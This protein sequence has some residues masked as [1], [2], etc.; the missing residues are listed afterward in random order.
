MTTTTK[1]AAEAVLR[2]LPSV[3]GAFVKEDVHGQPREVHLLVRPGPDAGG[4]SRDVRELLEDRLG[5]P[6]DQRVISIAQ[7]AASPNDE[8][9]GGAPDRSS[10]A[11][12]ADEPERQAD[13]TDADD[14]RLIYD[15]METERQGS[16][17]VV[18]VRLRHDGEQ[19]I[20]EAGELDAGHGRLRAAAG[21][22]ADALT[23]ACGERIRFDVESIATVDAS[24]RHYAHVAILALSPLLGRRPVSLAGA[25][26]VAGDPELATVLAT[27]KATNRIA[28]RVLDTPE[29]APNEDAEPPDAHA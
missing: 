7:I 28:E 4:L 18:R 22:T 26:P 15:G 12:G 1:D 10:T 6:V 14:R 16:R 9:N 2:E 20:G 29:A 19:H 27:L 23:A 11:A 24:A 21:A 17:V 8:T 5:I 25:H 3:L 13:R